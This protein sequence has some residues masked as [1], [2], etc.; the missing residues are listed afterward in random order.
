VEALQESTSQAK[1]RALVI[2]RDKGICSSCGEDCIEGRALLDA[3]LDMGAEGLNQLY[4]LSRGRFKGFPKTA[5]ETKGG[6][7]W[8][9]AHLEARV[10]GGANRPDNATTLCLRCHAADTK[11]LAKGRAFS[12]R[13]FGRGR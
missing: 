6:T 1:L 12:R 11:A 5:L 8:E 10:L 7:L 13:P 4:G 9:C 2:E 3:L